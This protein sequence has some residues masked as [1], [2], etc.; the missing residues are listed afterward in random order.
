MSK[1]STHIHCSLPLLSLTL[2]C[3][4]LVGAF[5]PAHAALKAKAEVTL[6]E[7][8]NPT[9]AEGDI[10]L[11]M[12][13]GLGMVFR[14][15]AV[16]AKGFLW[17][18]PARL[19]RDD[20]NNAE[21]AYYDS[22]YASAL[23][24]PFAAAD[25]PQDW[26]TALPTGNNYYYLIGKYEVSAL[27]WRAIMDT[28]HSCP[29]ATANSPAGPVLT[30]VDAQPKVDVS[31]YEAVDF[32]RSYTQWLLQNAPQSLPHFSGDQRNVG[33]LR[34]PTEG[35]WEYA[36]RGGHK[37]PGPWLA[38]EDFFEMPS[39]SSY[40]DYAV[41]RPEGAA[42]IEESP[43]R[44]GSR[45]AN[46]LGLHDTAGNAAEMV[47]DTFRFS[48]GG[49]LHGSAGGFVRK[50]GSYLSDLSQILPGR[51]EEVAFFQQNGP[52]H[53]KDMG[54][55]LVL[56][57]INT[58]A[59]DRPATLLQEWHKAG[60]EYALLLDTSRNPMEEL[61]R[62]LPLADSDAERKNLLHL[63]GVLKDNAIALERQQA[64]TAESLVRTSIYMIE[65]TRNYAIR[66]KSIE[67]QMQLMEKD[68]QSPAAKKSTFN[69]DAAI[70]KAR[71]GVGT[72]AQGVDESINFYRAK[73]E[74][75]RTIPPKVL[76][77][78]LAQVEKDSSKQ[79]AFSVNMR[80]NLAIYTKH[81]QLVRKGQKNAVSKDQIIKDILP[82]NIR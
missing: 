55:R 43:L 75:S 44:I 23:S 51:R 26:R 13:C 33:F 42:R 35:E 5:S 4:L 40:T 25:L 38:Q 58:P 22:R 36:A 79:D 77:A 72:M 76:D 11:P 59:G 67:N 10:V 24:G 16:P 2:L 9:P 50:G 48:L 71:E 57:G 73:I 28:A 31:W 32:S 30:P 8:W 63:R 82:A 65:T 62:L 60:E 37:T 17:D 78:A 29:P 41:F 21:R 27:Q 74:E 64:L 81:I 70:K 49:R 69:F 45:K 39:G 12:P 19:G 20:I 54:F 1:H 47:M 6:D 52:V 56:S 53:T 3:T 80:N 14:L 18:M 15:V 61:D 68:K 46:P 66:R 34:L 7:A